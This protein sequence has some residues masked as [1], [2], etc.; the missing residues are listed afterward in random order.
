MGYTLFVG[1]CHPSKM[2][3][4]LAKPYHSGSEFAQIS[5]NEPPIFCDRSCVGGHLE[6]EKAKKLPLALRLT[7]PKN[8]WGIPST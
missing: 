2:V 8:L 3:N 6:M 5:Q 7:S 1:Q 4:A